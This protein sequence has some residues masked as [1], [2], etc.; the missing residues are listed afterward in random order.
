MWLDNVK[1]LEPELLKNHFKERLNN[2]VL[3]NNDK[4]GAINNG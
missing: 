2:M 3:I 1:I 4:L